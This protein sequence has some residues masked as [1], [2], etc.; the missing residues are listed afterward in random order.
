VR[1]LV[2]LPFVEDER[3]APKRTPRRLRFYT[4]AT[5]AALAACVTLAATWAVRFLSSDEEATTAAVAVITR[6][7]NVQW[8]G[9]APTLGTPLTPGW[10]RLK[11]GLVQIEFYHGARVTLE[12]PAALRVLSSSAAYCSAGKLSAHVPPQAKGFRIETPKGTI[13]DLGTDFGLDLNADGPQVHVFKGEVEL[14]PPGSAIQSLKEGQA[15]ALA[16]TARTLVADESAFVSL[17]QIDERSAESQRLAFENWLKNSSAWNHDPGLLLHFDF[18]DSADTRA[19]F[20]HAQPLAQVTGGSIVG[21]DWTEGRW[22]GKR[23]LE[24]RNVS[25]RVR[26]SVPGDHVAI[27]F[28]AWVRINGLE[29]SFNSL[30]MVEGYNEGAVHWQITKEG[31]LRLGIANRHGMPA[32]DYDTSALFT[33]ERFGQWLHLATT[34]DPVAKE[35]RHY[36]NGEIIARVPR[37]HSFPVRLTVAELG[38]WNDAGHLGRVAIRHFSGVMDEFMLFERVLSDHEIQ[39]LAE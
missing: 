29:R 8:E 2:P 28:S 22:P 34:I 32:H 9:T 23:A 36:L 1:Q 15:M 4:L 21:C 20:N 10:L 26:L 24:F 3:E 11:S 39:R 30:F 6:G 17:S 14:H 7:V 25:D 27:T 19:L 37:V 12:G 5:V 35:V 33:P 16:N 31:A 13:V 18:Q 38:N